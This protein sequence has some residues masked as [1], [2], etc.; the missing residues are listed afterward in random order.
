MEKILQDIR[1]GFRMLRKAPGSAVIAVLTLAL[2]IGA[3]AAIFSLVD[4]I[5]L[6]PL[7]Y[8]KPARWL[9]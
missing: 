8:P 4:G 5:L 3:N 7:S 9:R 1:H 6:V 2:G